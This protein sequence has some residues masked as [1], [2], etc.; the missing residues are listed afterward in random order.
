MQSS[1]PDLKLHCKLYILGVFAVSLYYVYLYVCTS[2]YFLN[3]AH[4]HSQ[5]KAGYE[6][7]P[8]LFSKQCVC[9]FVFPHSRE[10]NFV[11]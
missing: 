11:C 2:V 1:D 10:H 7:V 4:A 9:I 3:Q 6:Y 5:L 8:G